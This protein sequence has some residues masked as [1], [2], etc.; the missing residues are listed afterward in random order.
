MD[1]VEAPVG[2][3]KRTPVVQ[4][5]DNDVVMV[6]TGEQVDNDGAAL[7]AGLVGLSALLGSV[8]GWR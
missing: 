8:L 6:K 7:G 3:E 4:D 2:K 5:K 1:S